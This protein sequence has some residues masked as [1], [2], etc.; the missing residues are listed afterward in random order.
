MKR[1]QY[2][3]GEKIGKCVFIKDAPPKVTNTRNIRRAVFKC[4]CGNLFESNVTS[5]KSEKTTSCGCVRKLLNKQLLRTHGMSKTPSYKMWARMKSRCL[6]KTN[7]GYKY[8]GGRGITIHPPWVHD[9]KA[10]HDYIITLPNALKKGYTIDRIDNSG[11]YEPG[12]IRWAD[13]HTQGAN[14]RS[15]GGAGGYTGVFKNYK[16]YSSKITIRGNVVFIGSADTPR[17]AAILRD[18]YIIK[19]KLWEYP[20][21]ILNS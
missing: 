4:G 8:Y 11:N 12:N 7:P 6:S 10:F 19:H 13:S 21:Q 1:I 15:K 5:V 18:E 2:I 9:F 16:R 14:Q 20:L 17:A 3:E